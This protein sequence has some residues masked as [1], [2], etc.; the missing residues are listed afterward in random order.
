MTWWGSGWQCAG[1]TVHPA[2]TTRGVRLPAGWWARGLAGHERHATQSPRPAWVGTV[3]RVLA[4]PVTPP[5]AVPEHWAEAF[6]IAVRPFVTDATT[7]VAH[8][9]G[10]TPQ[11][12]DTGA[13]LTTLSDWLSQ[14]LVSISAR[15]F[16]LEL[17]HR[18]TRGRL[19]GTDGRQR[20]ADFIRALAEPGELA[21]LLERYPVL[22][23]LLADACDQAAH[24]TAELLDRY[25]GDRH[26]IVR[27]LFKGED[28]GPLT[29]LQPGRGDPHRRGRT[30]TMLRFANGALTVYRP[31]DVTTHVR[32]AGFVR[33]LNEVVPH[34]DLRTVTVLARRGYG[35][36]EHIPQQ[37]M[38]EPEQAER[39]YR[40]QGALLALLYA[41]HA[42]DVHCE[43]LIAHE[44]WP[45]L[46]DVEMLFHPTLPGTAP[47]PAAEALANSVHRTA[48]LPFLLIGTHGAAD[49]SGLGGDPGP[50]PTDSVDWDFAGTDR[51][52][53]VR[54]P[55]PFAGARN[56]PELAGV[57]LDSLDYETALLQGFRLGYDAIARCRNEFTAMVAACA[58]VEVR[59]VARP[60]RT[61][62]SLVDESTHPGLLA[63]ALDRDR[64]LRTLTTA[65][66]L[67]RKLFHA[68]LA[69]M[70]AG[71]VP[72][73]LARAGA[74]DLWTANR[75]RL[76]GVLATSGL[77][78]S[79]A[80]LDRMG[81]VDRRDQEW[82]ISAS[83]AT[84]RGGAEHHDRSVQ[85][86][87]VYG[88]AA[89]PER[90]LAAAC[91][92]ADRI[93]ARS[94]AGADRVN[95]LG[96]ELVDEREWLVL[97][98]GGGLASG[99]LGVALFLA[100]LAEVSAI[101]RYA[102][103]AASA[104]TA[105][106]RLLETL[107][108]QPDLLRAIGPGGL[109]GLGGIGYG[110]ARLATLLADGELA[111]HASSVVDLIDTST[112]GPGWADG[113]AGC[114]AAMTA[115]HAELGLPAAAGVAERAAE[116]TARFVTGSVPGALESGFAH[117]WAGIATALAASRKH[118]K[119]AR[120]ARERVD[121]G[122][123]TRY[124]P[125]WC[126]GL[127][128]ALLAL[129]DK[130]IPHASSR[131]AEPAPLR[132][133]S[134]CHGELGIAEALTALP[135]K[136]AA[137]RRRAT[138]IL[139]AIDRYGPSCGTPNWVP[140]PGLAN[141]LAGIGYGLL[142][143]GFPDRVPAVLLLKPRKSEGE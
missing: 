109:Y 50:T 51:M 114:L 112:A 17:H 107:A 139:G 44:E 52:R 54:R 128:G 13:V 48:L 38:T 21:G 25:A 41:L 2:G 60:T 89:Y 77:A 86:G 58:D 22:A 93:V 122:A 110:L 130:E 42:A 6:A 141:G 126:R 59:V 34:L 123:A 39:F 16:V 99:Y 78:G 98:M 103:V 5:D 124:G 63:D 97:P 33:R 69:D 35:W 119:A 87:P 108:A 1:V 12:A 40:R 19:T 53:L 79:L 127:A 47:D 80:T 55:R 18:R 137:R 32:F 92:I 106:P 30:V 111:T 73:F 10:R 74:R 105:V 143:L 45:V 9:I 20:F 82:I 28:P 64:V 113:A 134:L 71:D 100:Q 138:L 8:R 135:G 120:T 116:H 76:R 85:P 46:V 142:R 121:L 95:W 7:R 104:L 68:E 94:L 15:T 23:R 61:Y 70:W 14:K 101:V 117:G 132:D 118:G 81:E 67:R 36:L 131:L 37:P 26:D 88:T 31:G 129:G 24:A 83:L 4:A 136:A 56:R 43:N 91:A 96:L 29:A 65:D 27:T 57:Q 66:P 11:Q 49:M 133:L 72:L 3:E 102:E 125:G 84:R 140:T 115:V 62:A 75:E 90:L